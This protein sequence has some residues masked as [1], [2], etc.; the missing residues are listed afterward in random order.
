VRIISLEAEPDIDAEATETPYMV[1]NEPSF[2]I[3]P[4]AGFPFFLIRC[5]VGQ[6]LI[7]EYE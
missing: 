7:N 6:N 5:A 3:L 2:L 4:N 1:T